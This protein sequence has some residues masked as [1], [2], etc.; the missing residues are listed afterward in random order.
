MSQS[1]CALQ[2]QSLRFPQTCGRLVI[3]SCWPSKSDSLGI[4]SPFAGSPA[5]EDWCDSQ[6][7][8]NSARISLVLFSSLWVTHLVGM[9]FDFLSWL[10]PFYRLLVASPLSLDVG[11]L[12]LVGPS[13]L[14]LMVQQ[15]VA[16][17][18]LTQGEDERISFYS[19][20]LNQSRSVQV[21][22]I[23][24]LGHSIHCRC[25]FQY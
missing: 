9:G 2:E 13:V 23:N 25:S 10:C 17:L 6:S 8:H 1:I 15:L 12:F 5:G 20:I 16:I 14:L 3:K 22:I 18:V 21:C 4:P 7:L 11:Y 19:V 24:Y